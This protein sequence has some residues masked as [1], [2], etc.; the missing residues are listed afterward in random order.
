MHS[1]FGVSGW[2][3]GHGCSSFLVQGIHSPFPSG[4]HFSPQSVQRCCDLI[5]TTIA[6]PYLQFRRRL[7]HLMH[8]VIG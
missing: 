7:R 8:S 4:H 6:I 5:F 1:T 3:D 2:H